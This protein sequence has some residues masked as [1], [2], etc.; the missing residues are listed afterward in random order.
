MEGIWFNGETA[1]D[2]FGRYYGGQ[3]NNM[4]YIA[5]EGEKRV[6]PRAHIS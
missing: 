1:F 4:A 6:I 5:R 2:A 3:Q